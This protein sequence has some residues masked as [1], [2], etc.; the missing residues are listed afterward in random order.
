MIPWLA[1][2]TMRLYVAVFGGHA[3]RYHLTRILAGM[4]EAAR[5]KEI[6]EADDDGEDG[7]EDDDED[8]HPRPRKRRP[9]LLP[10]W[11]QIA[12]DAWRTYDDE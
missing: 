8:D 6:L 10:V 3:A 7:E 2:A 12:R 1:G 4:M 5:Y 9:K 11:G